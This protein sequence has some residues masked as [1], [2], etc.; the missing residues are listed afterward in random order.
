MKEEDERAV[1]RQVIER[2]E[3]SKAALEDLRDERRHLLAEFRAQDAEWRKEV[4]RKRE[5]A[6]RKEE[7]ERRLKAE[8]KEK[9][10]RE[11]REKAEPF[12]A[13]RRLVALLQQYCSRLAS[14]ST[15][16]SPITTTV[17]A[18]NLLL[19]TNTAT[20]PS[21]L[22]MVP[23]GSRRRS[24]GFSCVSTGSSTYATP[25]CHTPNNIPSTPTC[26]SPPDPTGVIA[27]LEVLIF[28]FESSFVVRRCVLT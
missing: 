23:A 6:K 12:L 11:E 4:E 18:P 3:A 1:L 17:T 28:G 22:L 16:S 5:I 25:L 7:E 26:G 2:L 20:I 27:L 9:E 19:P 14:P 8:E 13:E 21:M 24:S 15:P 10:E